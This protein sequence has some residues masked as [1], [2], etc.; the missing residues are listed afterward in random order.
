[1]GE[2]LDKFTATLFWGKGNTNLRIKKTGPQK[3]TLRIKKNK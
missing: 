2:H 1:M 3:R